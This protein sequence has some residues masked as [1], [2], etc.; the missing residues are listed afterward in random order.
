MQ[1]AL[2]FLLLVATGAAMAGGPPSDQAAPMADMHVHPSTPLQQPGQA[3]FA[4]FSAGLPAELVSRF[5]M[6]SRQRCIARCMKTR[7]SKVA[8]G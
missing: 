4:A 5:A 1:F 7:S 2:S 3:A 8:S 6:L